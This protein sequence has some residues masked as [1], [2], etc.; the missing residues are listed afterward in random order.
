MTRH[1]ISDHALLRYI[2]RVCGV[3]VTELR[4]IITT[5]ELRLAIKM[6]ATA[7]KTQDCTFVIRNGQVVT[8]LSPDM[9]INRKGMQL[10]WIGSHPE[11]SRGMPE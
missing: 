1:L 4:R 7:L 3:D 2:E 5:E 10:P 11:Q 8:V 9:P 6:K